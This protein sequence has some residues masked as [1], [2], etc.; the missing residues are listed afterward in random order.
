[1]HNK[2]NMRLRPLSS[3]RAAAVTHWTGSAWDRLCVSG[4]W[5]VGRGKERGRCQVVQGLEAKG[6]AIDSKCALQGRH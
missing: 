1:M 5:G 4:A 6:F 3:P 2:C